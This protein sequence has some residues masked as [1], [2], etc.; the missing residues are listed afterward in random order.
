M[1]PAPWTATLSYPQHTLI[2]Y[3]L[4]VAGFA[5]LAGF[6]RAWITQGEV[7]SRYR[8]AVVARLAVTAI[9]TITYAILVIWFNLGYEVT[10]TGWE[11][12]ADAV[13]TLAPR[14]MSWSVSVPLLVAELLAVCTLVGAVAFRTLVLAMGSA[15]LMVF[16]GFLGAFVIDGGENVGQLLLWGA[17][18]A[19]F[20]V[21]TNLILIRAVRASLPGLTPEAA[22]L[23]KTAT[24]V[25]LS[26]WI[27]YPAAYLMQVFGSGGG[28]TTTIQILLSVAD[29]IVKIGFATLVHNIAKLR[30]AEDVRAG[31]DVHPESIWI[32]SVKQSD[33][34]LPSEVYLSREGTVH[35]PRSRPPLSAAVPGPLSE[36]DQIDLDH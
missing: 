34:G 2:Q 10:P 35:E 6:V 29:I 1:N 23:L 21:I 17:V 4:V 3:F 18:G 24:I 36:D 25:L 12:T 11:P 19:V 9:A 7:G 31:D 30:T 15:F 5:M 26:G 22:A 13:M 33:A 27:L 20:W 16:S 32:S 8:G 28:W 14:Y